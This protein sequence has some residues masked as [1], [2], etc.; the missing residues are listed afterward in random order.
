MTSLKGFLFRGIIGGSAGLLLGIIIGVTLF[1]AF[2]FVQSGGTTIP[3]DLNHSEIAHSFQVMD[4]TAT[5]IMN[6]KH[7]Q[8]GPSIYWPSYLSPSSVFTRDT[9]Y[10]QSI[11]YWATQDA[12]NVEV[13]MVILGPADDGK[14]YCV[15]FARFMGNGAQIT[16]FGQT[17]T[18][19]RGKPESKGTITVKLP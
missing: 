14:T 2:G 3:Y 10:T 1:G 7:L 9:Q 4:T 8:T 13:M 11:W 17:I 5:V 18:W 16:G 19:E 6:V 15:E 12:N